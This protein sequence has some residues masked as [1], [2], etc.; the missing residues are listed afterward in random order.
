M[1]MLEVRDLNVYFG[2]LLSLPLQRLTPLLLLF[3]SIAATSTIVPP[4]ITI[5][6]SAAWHCY[7]QVKTLSTR[8]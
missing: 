7:H 8:S 6:P 2:V 4:G 5:P 3:S 1:A